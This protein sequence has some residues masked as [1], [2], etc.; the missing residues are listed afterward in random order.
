MNSTI[1]K[2]NFCQ[3]SFT[4]DELVLLVPVGIESKE[5][6]LN[7]FDQG[8][9]FPD[10]F[11]S[12]WDAFNDCLTDLSWITHLHIAIVHNDLPLNKYPD[13]CRTYLEILGDAFATVNRDR[14]KSLRI[15]FPES[16]K[17]TINEIF[18]NASE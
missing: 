2:F 7:V 16:T 14:E 5:T 18:V 9:S 8:L 11:G 6:L 10:Y 15:F 17:T 1:E 12:N 13:N 3:P 4:N